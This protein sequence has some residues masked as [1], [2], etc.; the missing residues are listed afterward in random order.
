MQIGFY[1]QQRQHV[2]KRDKGEGRDRERHTDRDREMP[3]R[4]K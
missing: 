2:Y 3:R 1:T 4:R